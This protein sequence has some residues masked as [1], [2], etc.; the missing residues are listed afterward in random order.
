MSTCPCGSNRDYSDCCELLIRG[1]RKA[2]TAEEL[3]RARFSAY[4]FG[5]MDFIYQTHDPKTRSGLDMQA[6]K[7]WA[8]K[9][10]WL[11]L[12]ILKL[13]SGGENDLSGTVEFKAKFKNEDREDWHH[14]LSQ[15][16][17]RGEL[18]YFSDG[19]DPQI[20]TVIRSEKKIGRNDPC[21]CG[22][23]NKYKKCC[24]KN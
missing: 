21:S 9:T 18:W 13:V 17:K 12:Q 1:G 8:D 3:M 4:F 6:N 16:N 22:S 10:Q 24:G 11:E 19:K 20:Q 5:E 23:G 14:E 2:K 15:F 7:E